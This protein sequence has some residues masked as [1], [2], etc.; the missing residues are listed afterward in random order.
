MTRK[1]SI[2]IITATIIIGLAERYIGRDIVSQDME[3]CL[4]P[5]FEEIKAGGGLMSL[6]HQVGNYG[7]L[8]QT[9]I[10]LGT[11]VDIPAIY[12]YKLLSVAF[13]FLLA[14]VAGMIVQHERGRYGLLAA[15]VVLLLPTVA[16]NSAWWGQCDAMYT[17]FLLLTLYTLYRGHGI[18]AAALL[19]VAFACKLQTVF[20]VP[21]LLAWCVRERRFNI[22]YVVMPVATFWLA[23]AVAFCYG[24]EWLA[25]A[26][27]YFGQAGEYTEL[28]L[29]FP[30]FWLLGEKLPGF[31]ALAFPTQRIV[32]V[33]LAVAVCCLGA[34]RYAVK[35]RRLPFYP[36][37]AWFVW[38]MLLFLPAMH[39][40]YSYPLDVLLIIAA[41]GSRRYIAHA[42]TTALV[43][44]AL[45]TLHVAHGE[46]VLA[47]VFITAYLHYTWTLL[48]SDCQRKSCLSQH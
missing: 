15:A 40:R 2:I 35:G 10:A 42:V 14:A 9:L 47:L 38:T 31:S 6:R 22:M 43:S 7:L 16:A 32:A 48:G 13:D 5:W 46:M 36:V 30:S 17:T 28:H 24:R 19:G 11:Y 33:L 3:G 37:A 21:F 26:L 20:I 4:L 27:I 18:S 39:D 8:Y 1:N 34:Y 41:F 25:P 29:N 23:G 12:Q 45:Y 44:L